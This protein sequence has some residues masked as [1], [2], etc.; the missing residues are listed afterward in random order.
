[1]ILGPI[2]AMVLFVSLSVGLADAKD[3]RDETPLPAD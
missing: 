2:I 3:C 1:M